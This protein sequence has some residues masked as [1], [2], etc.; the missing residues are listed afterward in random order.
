MTA[1]TANF[2]RVVWPNNKNQTPNL[3]SGIF[4][5]RCIAGMVQLQEAMGVHWTWLPHVDRLP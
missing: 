4:H 5:L 3:I 2:Y 1:H